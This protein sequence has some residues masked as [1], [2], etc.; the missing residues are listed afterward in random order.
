MIGCEVSQKR[1]LNKFISAIVSSDRPRT[2]GRWKCAF[3]G[4][5]SLLSSAIDPAFSQD[6]TTR[7]SARLFDGRQ[8]IALAPLDGWL[9]H[10]GSDQSWA[11]TGLDVSGWKAMKPTELSTNMEDATGRV[12]GW[13]RLKFVLDSSF[14]DVPLGFSRNLWAATDLYLDG[15]LVQ[16]F[17]DTRNPYKAYNPHHQQAIPVNL[18]PGREYLLALH[19]VDYEAT[20]TQ[21]ELRLKPDNLKHLLYLT[22][23]AF[24]E[25]VRADLKKAHIYFSVCIAVSLLLTFLFW[26]LVFLNPDQRIFRYVAIL[27]SV[28]LLEAIF[29]SYNTFFDISYPVEKVRFILYSLAGPVLTALTLMIAEWVLIKRRTLISPLI[30]ILFPI[31][32]VIAHLFNISFPYGF[33][34]TVMVAY[35]SY[36]VYSSWRSLTAAHWAVIAGMIIPI[37]AASVFV[38]LHKYYLD[39]YDE[40]EK[41]IFLVIILGAPVSLL[42]YISIRYKEILEE[43]RD[44]ARKV[45]Q[46]SEEKKQLLATQNEVLEKQVTERT[47]ELEH[48]LATLKATQEQL[49]Q[50]EKLASLG[51]LTAGIAHEIKNP[52][53]FVNNFSSVSVELVDE[54][55]EEMKSS[56]SEVKNEVSKI[57][58][59][60]KTN[61]SKIHEH[62]SRAD[63]IVKSMLQHS[64]GSSGTKEPTNVNALTQEFVNLAFHG[65]RAG[66]NPMNVDV[67]LEL[68]EKVGTLP[69]IA[70]DFSRVIL[71][72]CHNAFDAMREKLEKVKVGGQLSGYVPKLSVRTRSEGDKIT[73]TIEDNGPGIPDEIKDK[74]L[75]PFFTTK[76][77][78]Q[79]TGLGLSITHDIVKAHGGAIDVKS[80]TSGAFFQ[81]ILGKNHE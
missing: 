48:S 4:I 52:L 64:R 80:S 6:V 59:D 13:F 24:D 7:L 39:L 11:N 72:L 73:I 22:G 68:D 33:I 44:E 15:V 30:L 34:N 54:A 55:I 79:G 32:S 60:L 23:P 47:A 5:I 21:R 42:V 51:Q 20:F 29:F 12:E 3:I 75:Q 81:V 69:L 67:E 1:A 19:V 36:L 74:I 71:N 14:A 70:E 28:V 77:G 78:T 37:L 17:G 58:A 57:L 76:R 50:Q 26:L 49:V 18:A 40:V 63:G 62:G 61:L 31:A 2:A 25:F 45:L 9:F 66:K 53:N 35:F 43:T 27:S 46:I 38:F 56:G 41:E 65:M 8:R 10:Q 16:S